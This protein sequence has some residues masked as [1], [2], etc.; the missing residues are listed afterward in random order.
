MHNTTSELARESDNLG[1]T[2]KERK[3]QRGK[4]PVDPKR[5]KYQ[6]SSLLIA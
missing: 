1:A 5:G 6:K 4:K 2:E 3:R